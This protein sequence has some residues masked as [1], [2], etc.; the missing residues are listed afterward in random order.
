MSSGAGARSWPDS[1]EPVREGREERPPREREAEGVARAVVARV[2]GL[3]RQTH[4][5]ERQHELEPHVVQ[6]AAPDLPHVGAVEE[7]V[8]DD[9][10]LVEDA[11]GP[12]PGR[13]RQRMRRR[14]GEL[15]ARERLVGG[16]ARELLAAQKGDLARV[17]RALVS[18]VGGEPE[19]LPET[20]AR[21]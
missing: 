18:V 21:T 8:G 4:A 11:P 10:G 13:Q 15:E 9:V 7:V 5:G 2:L 1:T 12:E 17:A 6:H 19:A 16:T 14:P 20:P 3:E